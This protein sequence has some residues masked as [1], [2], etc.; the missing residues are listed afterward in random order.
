MNLF[1]SK[2]PE[3]AVDLDE[4]EDTIRTYNE[5]RNSAPAPR[6]PV[7]RPEPTRLQV[8]GH[9]ITTLTWAEAEAMGKAIQSRLGA[10]PSGTA[11]NVTAAIQDWAKDWESFA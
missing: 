7:E 11:Q 4:L 2:Q 3:E 5:Q 9:A 6:R 1:G 8:I 10:E